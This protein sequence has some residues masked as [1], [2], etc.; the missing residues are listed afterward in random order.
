MAMA[1]AAMAGKFHQ[2]VVSAIVTLVLRAGAKVVA[3][4]GGCFH[5]A[6][7]LSGLSTRLETLG[8]HVLC[9]ERAPC[10]D[11]GLAL[12]QAAIASAKRDES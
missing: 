7:L 10:G 8:Y 5:N 11:G 1:P 2:A 12:G 9:Q 3:L 6:L 4:S